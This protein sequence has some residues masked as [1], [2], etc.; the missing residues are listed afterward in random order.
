MIHPC[1]NFQGLLLKGYEPSVQFNSLGTESV[2]AD[3][4]YSPTGV[5]LMAALAYN[6]DKVKSPPTT[7]QQLR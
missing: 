2:P 3:K 6:K 7:W 1:V 4:S 5:T